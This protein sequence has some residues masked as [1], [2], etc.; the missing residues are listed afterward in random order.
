MTATNDD[1]LVF[2]KAGV[3]LSYIVGEFYEECGGREALK[4]LTTKQVKEIFIKKHTEKRQSSYCDLLKE[5]GHK[6]YGKTAQVFLSHAH[7][8]EFLTVVD[9]LQ[10]HL[11]DQPDTVIW[12]DLFSI[13]QHQPMD[14]TFEWLSTTFKSSVQEIGRTIMP[15]SLE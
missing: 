8:S 12:F 14:W 10:W 1:S 11:R 7:Q 15:Q 13:N 4:G 5:Q 9:A 2:P 3:Q 6:A